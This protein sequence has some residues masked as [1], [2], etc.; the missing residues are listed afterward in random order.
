MSSTNGKDLL[1]ELKQLEETLMQQTRRLITHR[2]TLI[3]E[4]KRCFRI[5]GVGDDQTL[6]GALSQ[7]L[8]GSDWFIPTKRSPASRRAKSSLTASKNSEVVRNEEEAE[9]MIRKLHKRRGELLNQLAKKDLKITG[10]EEKIE[11]LEKELGAI[12]TK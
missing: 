12:K 3:E 11:E 1:D 2:E 9:R 5:L 6:D 7:S 10:M 8:S 4:R